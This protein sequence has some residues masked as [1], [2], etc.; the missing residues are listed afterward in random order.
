MVGMTHTPPLPLLWSRTPHHRPCFLLFLA[1][2]TCDRVG[3]AGAS[4]HGVGVPVGPPFLRPP[5]F[6]SSSLW[7][8]SS[9]RKRELGAINIIIKIK[10]FWLMGKMWRFM[11]QRIEYQRLIY[12]QQHPDTLFCFNFTRVFTF[13][14][15]CSNNGCPFWTPYCCILS[16]S[17]HMCRML[18]PVGRRGW[19][20]IK[21]K[22]RYTNPAR[23]YQPPLREWSNLPMYTFRSFCLSGWEEFVALCIRLLFWRWIINWIG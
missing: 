4:V 19:G 15:L 22:G 7:A 17:P 6:S 2:D 13:C 1:S 11:L 5:A 3:H 20:G 18:R 21:T 10:P 12:W 9:W 16:F 14:S 8:P 23:C